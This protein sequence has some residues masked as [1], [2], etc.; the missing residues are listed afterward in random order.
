MTKK[1]GANET[2]T[3]PTH[4]QQLAPNL[5]PCTKCGKTVADV[6]KTKVAGEVKKKA[7][8]KA[9]DEPDRYVRHTC[10]LKGLQDLLSW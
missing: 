4:G 5:P 6:K 3:C 7:T 10:G 8:C 1:T 9:C 2:V